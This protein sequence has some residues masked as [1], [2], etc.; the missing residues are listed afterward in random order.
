MMMLYNINMISP[1]GGTGTESW[2]GVVYLLDSYTHRELIIKAVYPDLRNTACCEQG[3]Q[4][5]WP[6]ASRSLCVFTA[7]SWL[8]IIA[9]GARQRGDRLTADDATTR[10]EEKD[11][12]RAMR[13]S[14]SPAWQQPA[15]VRSGLGR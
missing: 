11:K 2:I 10:K 8:S 5:S 6:C 4:R 1:R 9:G 7:I 15:S 13:D 3:E 14:S 12:C